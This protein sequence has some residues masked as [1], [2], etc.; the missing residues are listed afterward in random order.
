MNKSTLFTKAHAIAR[1]TVKLVGNY[2]I[3]LSLALKE[4]YMIN[5]N[6]AS[7]LNEVKNAKN[8]SEKVEKATAYFNSIFGEYVPEQIEPA[9]KAKD[10]FW[11]AF[12]ECDESGQ[13]AI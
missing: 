1:N 11:T 12:D 13:L 3:A 9:K 6:S 10:T 7:L 4:V 2:S 8:N 5:S